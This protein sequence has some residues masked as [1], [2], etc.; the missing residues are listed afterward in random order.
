[1]STSNLS[2]DKTEIRMGDLIKVF[3][4]YKFWTVL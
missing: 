1:M 2:N 3:Y 4:Q